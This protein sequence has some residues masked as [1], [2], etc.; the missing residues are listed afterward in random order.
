DSEKKKAKGNSPVVQVHELD[1][2]DFE[3]NMRRLGPAG[4]M[5]VVFHGVL[6]G[7]FILLAPRGSHAVETE[8][9]DDGAV[10]AES[11]DEAIRAS[12]NTF[13][14]NESSTEREIDLNYDV[15]RRHHV[16]VPGADNPDQAVGAVNA[17][18]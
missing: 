8:R 14:V 15:N 1:G 9:V 7:L 17:E 6:L 18:K 16:S 12:F 11:S 4:L 10:V 13:D 3:Q 5:S 2:T